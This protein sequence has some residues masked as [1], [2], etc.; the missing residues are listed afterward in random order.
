MS[1]KT[2]FSFPTQGHLE[3]CRKF[4]EEVN[5]AASFE[6]VRHWQSDICS[7]EVLCSRGEKLQKAGA[8]MLNLQ[9]GTVEGMS[10]DIALLQTMAWPASPGIP[11]FIIMACTSRVEGQDVMV[12]FYTD[13]II[14]N[15]AA[16]QKD[17]ET[18]ASALRQACEQHGQ[19]LEEYQSFLA[20]RGML[21]GCAAECGIL[22]FFE[23]GDAALLADIM[24]AALK[25][26]REIVDSAQTKKPAA[27][28]LAAMQVSR[29]K[30]VAW[31]LS[32][33]YGVKVARQNNIPLEIMES[34]GFPPIE[35][36]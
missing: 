36:C 22:Y 9:G 15:D 18:F 2:S 20:G 21:G 29:D 5:G 13:L 7:A 6:D 4:Y 19:S 32:E 12:T 34:Y 8:A 33:D 26:Y 27:Q 11:G 31:I 3:A 25:A 28:D 30:I 17:K 35:H 1:A 10:A 14:Q 16:D 24:A 23:E